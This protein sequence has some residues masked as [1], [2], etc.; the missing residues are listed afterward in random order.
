MLKSIKGSAVAVPAQRAA[1]T[2]HFSLLIAVTTSLHRKNQLT[3][4]HSNQVEGDAGLHKQAQTQRIVGVGRIVF[5][6]ECDS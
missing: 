2:M 5:A 4:P 3:Q 1:T 6:A